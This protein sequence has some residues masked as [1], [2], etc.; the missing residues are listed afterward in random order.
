M[1]TADVDS[2]ETLSDVLRQQEDS[3]RVI[4]ESA[5]VGIGEISLDPPRF[6][7]VNEATCKILEYTKEELLSMNPFDLIAEESKQFFQVRMRKILV[8]EKVLQSV[9]YKLKTKNGRFIWVNLNVN[10]LHKNGKVVGGLIFAQDTTKRKKAEDE[11]KESEERFFKAFQLSPT[12]MA[13]SF[14]DGEFVDVNRSFERLTG[15]SRDEVIGKR[16]VNLEMYGSAS[17]RQE[18]IRKL[19]QDGHVYNFPMTFNN[20]SMK[21]VNVLFSL[22]QIK[23]QN[24]PFVLG[25]AI[26]V[27]EKNQLQTELEK[28]SRN[29]EERVKQKTKQLREAERLAAIGQTAGMVGHDIRNPL[30]TIMGELYLL[31]CDL[32]SI[33]EGEEKE[34]MKESL[35]SI[36]KSIDYIDKIVQDL[37]DYARPLKPNLQETDFEEICRGLLLEI[38]F[39]ENIYV[40]CVVDDEAKEIIADPT[41][42]KRILSNLVNNAIQAMP[43]GGKLAIQAVREPVWVVITVE[44][45]G[46]GVPIDVKDMLFKPLFTT[47]SKGQGFG[48]AVVKR[49]TEALGGTIAFESEE[50]KGTKFTFRLKAA[51]K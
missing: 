25:A 17:E 38:G 47:K 14:T 27:T 40:N 9:D 7:W 43:D 19:Q 8:G 49:M 50:G 37:Q 35:A 22:E 34:E 21:H 11:L 2:S 45:S 30:Q 5:P 18:L 32:T 13:I 16:G 26:D 29:L 3:F 41:F 39:P 23:L 10:L 44:D 6:K 42:L 24:K 4:V 31:G 20:R 33:P 1:K 28:Y 36:K 48:L 46:V 12:P 51:K 15:F